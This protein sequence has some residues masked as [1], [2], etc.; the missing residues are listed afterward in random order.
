MTVPLCA[1]RASRQLRSFTK[2]C[3]MTVRILSVS[4]LRPLALAALLATGAQ[5]P[6]QAAAP[7][8]ISYTIP[9][10][11]LAAALNRYAQ[12][13]GVSI[14]I[15]ASKV[16]GLTTAGLQ[17]SYAIDEGF[18]LLLRGSGYAIGK[19]ATGYVLLVAP[20]PASASA[21]VE[22]S[23]P[24]ITVIGQAVSGATT[25]GSGSYTAR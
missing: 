20:A 14:A 25:E 8:T 23:M 1:S 7:A 5:L 17:G 6:A 22:R 18:A 10:G 21:A 16:Q 11:P 12:Q 19:T 24:A 9:A 13:S 4:S 15:D 3:Y 2:G